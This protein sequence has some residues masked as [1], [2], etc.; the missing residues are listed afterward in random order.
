MMG[1]HIA[2]DIAGRETFRVERYDHR[3][4]VVGDDVVP[5]ACRGILETCQLR[6]RTPLALALVHG[7]LVNFLWFVYRARSSG[8]GQPSK[9]GNEKLVSEC[10]RLFRRADIFNAFLIFCVGQYIGFHI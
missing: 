10:R 3:L 9:Y 5:G 2:G 1:F 6:D 7:Y 4:L 8:F